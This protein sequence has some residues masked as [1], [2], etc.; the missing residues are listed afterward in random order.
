MGYFVYMVERYRIRYFGKSTSGPKDLKA[1]LYLYGSGHK[2]GVVGTI[3]FYMPEGLETKQDQLDGLG[4]PQGNMSITEI[5]AVMDM[6]R[7]EKPIYVHWSELWKQVL[8][9]TSSEPVGEEET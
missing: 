4:R 1:W 9:D 3:G 7:N 8:L 5:V 2:T 6:L